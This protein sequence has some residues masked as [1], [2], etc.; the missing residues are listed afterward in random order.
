VRFHRKRAE[1]F[2]FV[3]A[4]L[5]SDVFE[6]GV[7]LSDRSENLN[8]HL[9]SGFRAMLIGALAVFGAVATGGEVLST[10]SPPSNDPLFQQLS[11]M[12]GL[13]GEVA[14]SQGVSPP[15][16]LM[17]P[18]VSGPSAPIARPAAETAAPEP[19]AATG[20]AAKTSAASAPSATAMPP[21]LGI[22]GP[23]RDPRVGELDGPSAPVANRD[24]ARGLS[25]SAPTLNMPAYS[26]LGNMNQVVGI[27]SPPT[28]ANGGRSADPFA[29]LRTGTVSLTDSGA[30]TGR[31]G[32]ATPFDANAGK[33]K[34]GVIPQFTMAG[35]GRG[36]PG[37]AAADPADKKT[38]KDAKAK[39]QDKKDAKDKSKDDQKM[40]SQIQ[41]LGSLK[42][43]FTYD[44]YK[45]FLDLI[46]SNP[47]QVNDLAKNQ[48]DFLKNARTV[49]DQF[50]DRDQVPADAQKK[51]DYRDFLQN[52][53]K[54]KPSSGSA[55]DEDFQPVFN[56]PPAE[57]PP[58]VEVE[59]NQVPDQP[60]H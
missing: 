48:S 54:P 38:D 2:V 14:T 23:A 46:S 29:S 40:Q 56:G 35:L 57:P 7:V 16:A 51:D 30:A 17:A 34:F 59:R 32:R 47:E 21:E 18:I 13:F 19:T 37:E 27:L 22:P 4:S 42:P 44:Q 55:I 24:E 45:K 31:D 8:L 33:A 3:P 49:F 39:D 58:D 9:H 53:G 20:A 15:P 6:N 25:T 26:E 1:P 11:A 36:K 43:E 52:V 12:Q 50:A 5:L 10:S 60:S 28:A 41:Q